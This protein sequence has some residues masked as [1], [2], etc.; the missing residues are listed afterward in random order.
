MRDP[1]PDP[2]VP[3]VEPTPEQKAAIAW[4][5]ASDEVAPISDEALAAVRV[6]MMAR[7]DRPLT[8]P[9]TLALLARLDAAEARAEKLNADVDLL[10]QE[11]S[12]YHDAALA[13]EG[14][15]TLD[16]QQWRLESVEA[17]LDGHAEWLYALV[18]YQPEVSP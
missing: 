7:I 17:M 12:R 2:V 9:T 11:C 5:E 10:I 13:P 16:G 8:K 14:V 1:S 6:Q 4:W 3:A 18:P 15:V